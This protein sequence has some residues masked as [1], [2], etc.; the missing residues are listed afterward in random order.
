MLNEFDI[1]KHYFTRNSS[2]HPEIIQGIGDDAAI[3]QCEGATLVTSVDTMLEGRHFFPDC[4]PDDL[5]YK[6]LAVNLSDF[7]AMGATPRWFTLALTL[8][9]ADELWLERFSAS[10]FNLA[11]EFNLALIG[12]DT[13]QGPLSVT[14]Q[15]I[16]TI[17]KHKMLLRSGAKAGDQIYVSGTLGDAGLALAYLQ[18]KI[19]LPDEIA[20]KVLTQFNRPKPQVALGQ[21][22]AGYASA[23]IDISDGLAQDLNHILA[24]S[25]K[26]ADLYLEKLPLS[27]SLKTLPDT[28][29]QMLA[30]TSG[31]DY[32]LCFTLAAEDPIIKQLAHINLL[33]CIG[34]ITTNPGLRIHQQGVSV[35][36]Q[37]L[38]WQHFHTNDPRS[39]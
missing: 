32:Q 25:N 14:I 36:L 23:A 37:D 33:T 3:W 7:A 22:L 39:H 35:T 6:A 11:Q 5:A 29:A 30:L 2:G 27:V 13:T 12:G 26:G 9:K 21:A 4:S 18:K 31:D 1:I 34:E 19:M 24:A 20:E 10:L 8:P 17:N 28:Q 15:I 16:G 38:G